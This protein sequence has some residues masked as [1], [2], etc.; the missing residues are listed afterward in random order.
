[1][2]QIKAKTVHRLT[3]PCSECNRTMDTDFLFFAFRE[4][5]KN[6]PYQF[7]FMRGVAYRQILS[8]LRRF[9]Y[10]KPT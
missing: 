2:R 6:N 1:M 5:Q 8:K 9:S 10:V 3:Q 7:S 4:F